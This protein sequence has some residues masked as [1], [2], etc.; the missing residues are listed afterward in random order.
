MEIKIKIEITSKPLTNE[1]REAIE[2]K[3]QEIKAIVKN[4]EQ[5]SPKPQTEQRYKAMSKKTIAKWLD[6]QKRVKIVSFPS[7]CPPLS[8][9][10]PRVLIADFDDNQKGSEKTPQDTLVCQILPPISG[11]KIEV[12]RIGNLLFVEH[13]RLR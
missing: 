13:H 2:E 9:Q 1:Q 3:L 11:K 6:K 4:E 8:V 7:E 5:N 10:K 12:R